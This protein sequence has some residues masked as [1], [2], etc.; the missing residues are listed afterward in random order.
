MRGLP[1]ARRI[2]RVLAL[3]AVALVLTAI[4]FLQTPW[5][6]RVARDLIQTQAGRFLDGELR[7]GS[8]DGGFFTGLQL[9]DVALVDGGTAVVTISSAELRYSVLQIIRGESIVI[10]SVKLRGVTV[11]AARTPDGALNV[12]RILKARPSS[13]APGR[14]LDIRQLQIENATVTFPGPW[15]PAWLQLPRRIT[16]LNAALSLNA[17]GGNVTLPIAALSAR[18]AAPDFAIRQF[19]GTVRFTPDGW[20]VDDA[21]LESIRTDARFSMQ[22]VT[23]GRKRHYNVSLA[24]SIIDFPEIAAVAPGTRTIDVPATVSLTMAGPEDRLDTH[25]TLESVAGNIQ[26]RVTLNSTVPGWTGTGTAELTEFDVSRWLPTEGVSRITGRAEFDLVLGLGRHFPR[27]AFTFSGPR[28]RYVGYEATH[29]T[30]KGRLTQDRAELERAAGTAYGA[31]ATARGWISIAAP[32]TFHLAGDLRALDLRRLPLTV[33]VPRIETSLAFDYDAR[34]RFQEPYLSGEAT[35]LRSSVLGATI[36]PGTKGALDSSTEPVRYSAVGHISDLALERVGRA[37]DAAMLRRPE[38]RGTLSGDVDVAGQGTTTADLDLRLRARHAT[39]VLFGGTFHRAAFDGQVVGSSLRGKVAA[40][41]Q[42]I[43]AATFSGDPR[44]EGEVS[45]RAVLDLDLPGLFS[46]GLQLG[47]S[48]VAGS[49][50]LASSRLGSLRLDTAAFEGSL[51]DGMLRLDRGDISGRGVNAEGRGTIPVTRGEASFELT[52]RADDISTLSPWLGSPMSGGLGLRGDVTGR[53][54]RLAVKGSFQAHNLSSRGVST[55]TTTGEF[56]GTVADRSVANLTGETKFS[57]TF[58]QGAGWSAPS[59]S[60]RLAYDR[61]QVRGQVEAVLAGGRALKAS[62]TLVVHADHQ[63]IHLGAA[64][65]EFEKQAWEVAPGPPDAVVAWDAEA[66]HVRGLVLTAAATPNSRISIDGTLGRTTPLGAITV[67]AGEMSVQTL[68]ALVPA[69]RDYHGT[70]SGTVTVS[71]VLTSPDFG[72]KISVVGGRFRNFA[73]DRLFV[74]GRTGGGDIEGE[75]RLDQAAGHWLEA[76]GTVPLN[77]F[78]GTGPERPVNLTVRSSPIDLGV[79]EGFTSAVAAVSGVLE[80]DVVAKGVS[81]DPHFEGFV[82]LT[83]AAFSVAATGASYKNGE[84][85]IALAPDAIE[86][87][88]FRLE[89]DKGDPLELTG[90]ASTHELKLGEFGIELSANR[91]EILQNELGDVDLNGVVTISGSPAAP[92]ISGDLAIHRGAL[93]ADRLLEYFDRP[94][95]TAPQVVSDDVATAVATRWWDRTSLRLRVLATN[96]LTF[97]GDELRFRAGS[98]AGL[99]NVNVTFGGDVTL[100]KRPG[101][102]VSLTGLLTTERGSY[103][104]QGRRFDIERGGTIR[105]TGEPVAPSISLAAERAVSGV[106]VRV[107]I[108]G[109]TT[110]PELQLSSRPGLEQSDILSLLLFGAPANELGAGQRQE[111]AF[112]AATLA[113]G[114]VVSPAVTAVGRALGLDYL[115]LERGSDPTAANL[116]LRAGREVWPGLYVTYGREFGAADYNEFMIEYSLARFLRL[117]AKISDADRVRSREAL[118]RRVERAGI[119]LI[120]FFS[121]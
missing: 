40:E 50:H 22:S 54:D 55:L 39:L 16:N 119:D 29:V 59:F 103:A 32:Y 47:A 42:G 56:N 88:C 43:N 66:I 35:F 93:A 81:S 25:A 106:N 17:G 18:G 65:V 102:G 41:F 91:F 72:A 76:K 85:R 5:A 63:E 2:A 89:D 60:G 78:S 21:A 61:Q 117:R 97:R 7:V 115:E 27:G 6:R 37:F 109:T 28:A 111:V 82:Q 90:T 87:E 62:G 36:S 58:L 104:F 99:G 69:L 33:P 92:V 80:V 74:S 118:F 12:S 114:F 4:V 79:I 8:V 120:F 19:K 84:V 105:F 70:V 48:A 83:G 110:A 71:G 95:A 49:V 51:T 121:Y 101:A 14:T 73:F 15:G 68:T 75:L 44:L 57:G 94:Y 38:Y 113:S 23:T 45:G 67:R 53:L 31:P 108:R 20:G 96:N 26:T 116:R 52:A 34:G 24:R 86:I 30:A 3:V 1:V 9:S 13:G 77:L 112:Q 11:M 98:A 10:D 107:G 64:R 100:R 46:E